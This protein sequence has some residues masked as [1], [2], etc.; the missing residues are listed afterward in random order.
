MNF[1]DHL[2]QHH[3]VLEGKR[4]EHIKKYHF[5]SFNFI[6]R[7]T[8]QQNKTPKRLT[9]KHLQNCHIIYKNK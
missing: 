5:K 4:C 8:Q 1:L 9:S 3:L 2:H 7:E 6:S